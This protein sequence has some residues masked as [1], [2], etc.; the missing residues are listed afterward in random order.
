[1]IQ[2]K[3]F[4][5]NES[6]SIKS[7]LIDTY[8]GIKTRLIPVDS[9]SN[10]VKEA[11]ENLKP[12]YR[13]YVKKNYPFS[14]KTLSKG[15]ES[16]FRGFCVILPQKMELYVWPSLLAL[17]FKIAEQ[18]N[19]P[20]TS[21]I[22]IIVDDN[23]KEFNADIIFSNKTHYKNMVQQFLDGYTYNPTLLL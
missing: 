13:N 5:L 18:F 8:K 1:M 17:H 14:Y 21:T 9:K 12:Y 10:N 4:Y 2:F 15:K 22:N 19:I 11:I 3:T 16:E 23:K 6:V 7:I 20:V